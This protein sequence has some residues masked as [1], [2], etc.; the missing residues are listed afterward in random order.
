[1]Q[2]PSFDLTTFIRNIYPGLLAVGFLYLLPSKTPEVKAILDS[3]WAIIAFVIIFGFLFNA[4]NRAILYRYVVRNI[5]RIS[6]GVPQWEFH[7]TIVKEIGAQ[8]NRKDTNQLK[9]IKRTHVADACS[10]YVISQSPA[11]LTSSIRIFNA[12]SHLMFLTAWLGLGFCILSSQWRIYS[13]VGSLFLMCLSIIHDHY[14]SDMRE[15]VV[16]S[17]NKEEYKRLVWNYWLNKFPATN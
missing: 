14:E 2:I 3:E 17:Q 5:E 9:A 7:N 15:V 4:F 16:L 13:L 10:S 6:C 1:M 12:F 8:E 11:Q